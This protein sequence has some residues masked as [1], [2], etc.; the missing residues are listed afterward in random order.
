MLFILTLSDVLQPVV[1]KGG[2]VAM[3][4]ALAPE[5][6]KVFWLGFWAT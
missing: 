5:T 3:D 4:R 1:K 2:C 6:S